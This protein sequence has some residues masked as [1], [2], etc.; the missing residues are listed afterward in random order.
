MS[1]YKLKEKII[2][3][4]EHRYP[5]ID[6]SPN[7]QSINAISELCSNIL[8]PLENELGE[9]SITY[10]FTSHTL[11][12]KIQNSDALIHLVG[13]GKQSVNTKTKSEPHSP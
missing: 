13:I 2:N 3:W 7:E 6:N 8:L 11:L 4:H 9:V 12:K 10:G 5:N 1:V